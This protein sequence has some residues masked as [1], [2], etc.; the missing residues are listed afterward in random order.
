[1]QMQATRP[2]RP[3]TDSQAAE[4]D[5]FALDVQRGLSRPLKSIPC[6]YLYD[7]RGS[8]LFE[9]ITALPEYYLTGCEA[10]IL[11]T[12]AA[13]IGSLIGHGCDNLV[14]LGAGDG[15]K[16]RILLNGLLGT[17]SRPRYVPVDCSASAVDKLAADAA[18]W[19]PGLATRGM[20]CDYAEALRWLGDRNASGNLVVF[21]GS[22]I[23]NFIPADRVGFLRAVQ[24]ALGTGDLALIGFDLVKDPVRL[25]RAYNDEQGVT[26]AFNLNLLA[27]CNR[28]LGAD[29]APEGF[30]FSAHW[31]PLDAAVHSCLVSLR[32][33]RVRVDALDRAFDFAAWEPL[34]TESSYKFTLSGIQDLARQ[35]GFQVARTFTDPRRDFAVALWRVPYQ[36]S[37]IGL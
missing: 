1:M 33:Q 21:L 5:D 12:H 9:E 31:D 37:G 25:H 36:Q 8:A 34:H 32:S 6:K 10:G 18:R 13:E 22:S 15:H 4:R 16:T 26:R 19:F 28:E 20:V 30:R 24:A 23:G 2:S 7:A 35:A 3:Q 17:G 29:F 14:E 27:R 11:R